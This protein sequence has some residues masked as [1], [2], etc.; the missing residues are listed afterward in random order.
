ML[1]GYMRKSYPYPLE[2]PLRVFAC[3]CVCVTYDKDEEH[4]HRCEWNELTTKW[5]QQT[6][7]M[8]TTMTAMTMKR[9]HI[10]FE[11]KTI[12]GCAS[13][14]CKNREPCDANEWNLVKE[15]IRCQLPSRCDALTHA[16]THTHKAIRDPLDNT[17]LQVKIFE[18]TRATEQET[19]TEK[20]KR[21]AIRRGETV[22]GT[23]MGESLKGKAKNVYEL[24]YDNLKCT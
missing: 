18:E 12:F 21:G 15:Q 14:G 2:N 10:F 6:K 11:R 24:I 9:T 8:T 4:R 3:T 17:I 5:R 20:R 13:C 19:E 22:D 23:E 1:A 7:Q 16:H